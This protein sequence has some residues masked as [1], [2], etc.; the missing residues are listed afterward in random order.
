[1]GKAVFRNCLVTM[2]PKTRTKELPT[3]H[4]VIIYLHN[5]YIKFMNQIKKSLNVSCRFNWII[6]MSYC[7]EGCTRKNLCHCRCMDCWYHQS[8]FPRYDWSL[9]QCERWQL[10]APIYHHQF[11]G[12]LGWSL[13]SQPGMLFCFD[14]QMHWDYQRE[15]LKGMLH[16]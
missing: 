9:D 6:N 1:M 3:M 10:E 7:W 12:N 5:V 4:D 13:W 2:W 15:K 8:Q 16:I 14:L 11:Q